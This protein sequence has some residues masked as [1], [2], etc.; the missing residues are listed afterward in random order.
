MH[1]LFK[2]SGLVT[3]L[4]KWMYLVRNLTS[5]ASAL[6]NIV[7]LPFGRQIDWDMQWCGKM[8]RDHKKYRTKELT[9]TV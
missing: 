2:T 1:K 4:P 8:L 9:S 3:E 5:I 7:L 6:A